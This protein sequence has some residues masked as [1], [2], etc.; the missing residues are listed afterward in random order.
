MG[1]TAGEA[2]KRQ[3]IDY[4]GAQDRLGIETDFVKGIKN[5]N[6]LLVH[7]YTSKFAISSFGLEPVDRD[8]GKPAR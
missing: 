1:E 3:I 5:A 6:T 4:T 7:V 2:E 8:A